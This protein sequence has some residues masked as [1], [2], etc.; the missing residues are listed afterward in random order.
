MNEKI[1]GATNATF[2]P[3]L[4]DSKIVHSWELPLDEHPELDFHST[5][6]S[7]AIVP[8]DDGHARMFARTRTGELPAIEVQGASGV[9]RVRIGLDG[10]RFKFWRDPGQLHLVVC[11]P[12]SVRGRLR[13]CASPSLSPRARDRRGRDSRRG[14]RRA[15][16]TPVDNGPHPGLGRWRRA[17][18]S[19]D[20]RRA[21]T[22]HHA[23]RCRKPLRANAR[24]RNRNRSGARPARCCR[25]DSPYRPRP[26]RCPDVSRPARAPRSVHAPRR[27]SRL[28]RARNF[29]DS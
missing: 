16:E 5:F 29:G 28:G 13:H 22:P 9:T 10:D 8:V 24:R 17:P 18:R 25:R 12:E 6:A 19:V 23:T 11:V 7:L 1:D 14:C 4:P 15:F 21:A 2:G 20:G 3:S 27:H 26:G